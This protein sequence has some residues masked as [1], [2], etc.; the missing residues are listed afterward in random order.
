[1]TRGEQ[2]AT[3]LAAVDQVR[4]FTLE[5][6]DPIH[7]LVSRIAQRERMKDPIYEQNWHTGMMARGMKAQP[8]G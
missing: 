7:R 4:P 5:E 2:W 3:D 6:I 8:S 1:M